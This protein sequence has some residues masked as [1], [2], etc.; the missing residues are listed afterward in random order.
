M[1]RNPEVIKIR[2]PNK[3]HANKYVPLKVI[4]KGS[5][6]KAYL[7]ENSVDKVFN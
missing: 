1:N 5:F 6:G 7:V 4:G 2:E 3:I